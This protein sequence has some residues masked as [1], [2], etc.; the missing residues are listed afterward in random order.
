MPPQNPGCFYRPSTRLADLQTALLIVVML[1]MTVLTSSSY[2]QALAS[3][4]HEQL[5]P[6]A[7]PRPTEADRLQ[8]WNVSLRLVREPY[9][10][11][12]NWRTAFTR[13]AQYEYAPDVISVLEVPWHRRGDVSTEIENNL[14][15][16]YEFAH[17]DAHTD[18]CRSSGTMTNN[19]R[20]TLCGNTMIF[21][22]TPRLTSICDP[23]C[24]VMRWRGW[25][26]SSPTADDCATNRHPNPDHIAV[27]LRDT[28]QNRVVTVAS[29]HFPN[30]PTKCLAKNLK[31]MNDMFEA[32][33][34]WRNRPL[35]VVAGD[36]NEHPDPRHDDD[37]EATYRLQWRREENQACW[38]KRFSV[39]HGSTDSCSLQLSGSWSFPYH[40]VMWVE[41][42]DAP[43]DICK[44]WTLGNE[45]PEGLAAADKCDEGT[46]PQVK[47]RI[48]FMWVRYE[49]SD[50]TAITTDAKDFARAQVDAASVDQGFYD[51]DPAVAD[52]EVRYSDHRAL[53]LR[54]FWCSPDA[55][56]GGFATPCS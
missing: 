27:R 29:V 30:D 14:G 39:H 45:F 26:N 34:T 4:V 9:D 23:T 13:M 8:I 41:H 1:L 43:A 52:D 15:A 48:D 35:T 25:E 37:D 36:F 17:A 53:H 49:T 46:Q 16:G 54:V 20:R 19:E 31:E 56:L 5:R 3:S 18:P 2:D 10:T 33:T 40:D 6:S 50:G 55:V 28:E 22:R 38:Y 32:D 51:P 21:W 47:K 12:F 7:A 42:S 11:A 44:Q 24:Q